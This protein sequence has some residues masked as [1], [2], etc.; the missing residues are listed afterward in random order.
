MSLLDE[1]I[2]HLVNRAYCY[3]RL[4]GFS[5]QETFAQLQNLPNKLF[6]ADSND[7]LWT[8]LIQE[9]PQQS[10][11][12]ASLHPQPPPPIVRGHMHYPEPTT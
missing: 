4:N 5:A 11:H 8:I 9:F 7:E 6:M 1:E 3:L 12:I 2:I 10:A